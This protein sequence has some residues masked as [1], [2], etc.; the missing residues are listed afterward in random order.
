MQMAHLFELICCSFKMPAL[1]SAAVGLHLLLLHFTEASNLWPCLRT[2]S[3]LLFE[4][5]DV[6]GSYPFATTPWVRFRPILALSCP[7]PFGPFASLL[8]ALLCSGIC[9]FCRLLMA[10]ALSTG[11]YVNLG[12]IFYDVIYHRKNPL[13]ANL[14]PISAVSSRSSTANIALL[15]LHTPVC[16]PLP[17]LSVFPFDRELFGFHGGGDFFSYPYLR[18]LRKSYLLILN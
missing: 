3:Q 5:R 13:S 15:I 6:F 7:I 12:F 16:F 2:R 4:L 9:Y 18:Y 17:L 8:S 11:G 1:N 14:R 10:F